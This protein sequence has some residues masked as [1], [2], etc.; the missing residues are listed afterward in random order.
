[1]ASLIKSGKKYYIQ[2]CDSKRNPRLKQIP[3]ETSS[4]TAARKLLRKLEA[5]YVT[6]AYD[7]WKTESKE[8]QHEFSSLKELID[9]YVD[10]KSKTFW[11]ANTIL[12]NGKLLKKM[13]RKIGSLPI[14]K[15]TE[16]HFN[17]FINAGDKAYS[18]RVGYRAKITAFVNWCDEQKY[19]MSDQVGKLKIFKSNIGQEESINYFTKEDIEKLAS[20][21]SAKVAK[22][23]TTG[24][25]SN[26]RNALW[27]V[28]FIHWQRLSGMRLSET[29][30]L[31]VGDVNTDTWE[32]TIGNAHF[33]TKS[34]K[35]QVLPI[36][37]VEPLKEIARSKLAECS[38]DED[39]LFGHSCRRHTNR[40]FN[41][42]LKKALPK[43]TYLNIHSLRHTCCIELLRAGV[44]IYTVQRWLRH[45]DVKTTQRYADLLNMDISEQVGRALK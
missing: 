11:S 30:N 40:L 6:G 18:T 21:I 19:F 9:H 37:S 13:G 44:P 34:K 33:V 16:Y 12:T 31:R 26:N 22:D 4:K 15:A 43:K 32:I 3:T 38:S 8:E 39:R 45:A 1:M 27:L 29:L 17:K 14:E 42:Y 20:Y 25:Q 2:F 28:D 23:L 10:E 35:K 5:E 36:E 41:K 24:R 7:P